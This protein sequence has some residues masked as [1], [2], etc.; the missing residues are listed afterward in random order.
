MGGV[1]AVGVGPHEDGGTADALWLAPRPGARG[2][3]EELSVRRAPDK[4]HHGRLDARDRAGQPF[5]T[6]RIVGRRQLGGLARR[7]LRD[8]GQRE[9]ELR[10]ANVVR[11]RQRL[12]HEACGVEQAIEGITGP[13]EV[14]R[15]EE[16]TSELQSL[17]YLVCRLL[18]EKKKNKTTARSLIAEPSV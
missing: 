6:A 10:K 1:G 3:T 18:L 7:T 9:P 8:V 15:S 17:A 13:R 16:H 4:R 11:K 2:R 5:A 14:M 12:G